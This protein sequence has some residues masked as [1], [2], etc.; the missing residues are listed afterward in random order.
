LVE[1]SQFLYHFLPG[2][3]PDLATNPDA[4]TEADTKTSEAAFERLKRAT[5]D[6]IVI[7]AGRSL[8]GIGP[9]VVIFEAESEEEARCFIEGDPFVKEGLLAPVGFTCIGQFPLYEP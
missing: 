3:R 1:K 4:W 7:L 8:D 5:R 9:A 6:G 2:N